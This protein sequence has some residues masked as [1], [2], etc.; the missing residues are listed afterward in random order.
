ML[1]EL[2]RIHNENKARDKATEVYRK[3]LEIVPNDPDAHAFLGP[4]AATP[5]PRPTP[6][7]P[8]RPQTQLPQAIR[9]ATGE[10]KFNITSDL[11]SLP[12]PG[13]HDRLDAARRRAEPVERRLRAA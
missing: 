4:A 8:V 9:A 1:K 5:T 6:Q 2:A 13:A 10:A 7:P 12:A 3:I 11:Q